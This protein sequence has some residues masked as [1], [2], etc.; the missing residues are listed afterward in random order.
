MSSEKESTSTA[1]STGHYTGERLLRDRPEI[2][3]AITKML[4]SRVPI[5]QIKAFLGVHH[6]TIAAVAEREAP[7]F[8]TMRKRLTAQAAVALEIVGDEIIENVLEGRI[9]P[10]ELPHAYGTLFDRYQ[11]LTGGATVRI[12]KIEAEDVHA[13]LEK[14]LD[15]LPEADVKM[16]EE[17][18]K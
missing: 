18:G 12:E 3:E 5:K 11:L 6:L 13:Q 16:I 10:S 4:A 1:L 9:K 8:D 2:Y 15:E 7:S 14:Y 17:I